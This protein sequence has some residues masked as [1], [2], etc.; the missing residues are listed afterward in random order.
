MVEDRQQ[1]FNELYQEHNHM[2]YRICKK[3]LKD[4]Y[5]AEDA[6]Q[7]TF[8]AVIHSMDLLS[9]TDPEHVKRYICVIA[10][11]QSFNLYKKVKGYI[12]VPID[13]M[14]EKNCISFSDSMD[15][16]IEK[17]SLQVLVNSIMSL[18]RIYADTMVLKYVYQLS[19]KEIAERLKISE[20]SVRKR[21]ER[22][23]NKLAI[24]LN[25]IGNCETHS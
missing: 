1:L 9:K 21:L 4:D 25:N 14:N 23:R 24:S 19:S 12:Y 3:Y 13:T 22:G 6:M 7:N 20:V 18:P 10:R 8:E 17:E 11:N 5:L 16:V 2:V 15:E